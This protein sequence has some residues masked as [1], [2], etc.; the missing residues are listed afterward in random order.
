MNPNII[1][2][3]NVLASVDFATGPL[4]SSP[5]LRPLKRL[6]EELNTLVQQGHLLGVELNLQHPDNPCFLL[7]VAPDAPQFYVE[8]FTDEPFFDELFEDEEGTPLNILMNWMGSDTEPT[9]WQ[10]GFHPADTASPEVD[11]G[12][13]L[14]HILCVIEA[15]SQSVIK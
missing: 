8:L 11:F 14:S 13:V 7:N 10:T 12:E 4:A 3:E 1:P 15:G 5:L 6:A 9:F 2:L